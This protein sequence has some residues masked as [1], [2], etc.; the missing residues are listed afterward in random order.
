M[1]LYFV[2]HGQSM[3]NL[4]G[5]Y[6]SLAHDQLSPNGWQQAERLVE[7]LAGIDFDHIYVST[8]KRTI[9]TITPYLK[10]NSLRAKLWPDLQE[11]CWQRDRTAPAPP[12]TTPRPNFVMPQELNAHFDLLDGHQ[13]LPYA[14]EVY[15]ESRARIIEVHEKL[16]RWHGGQETTILIVGHEFAGGR[17]VDLLLG[18]EPDGHIY[19]TNTGLTHLTQLENGRFRLRFSNRV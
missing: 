12:R 13:T 9:Q 6:S 3:G 2:R 19:H 15:S 1:Q 16:M 14:G 5:D 17:L 7:R 11:A 10:H 4:T 18:L 8:A